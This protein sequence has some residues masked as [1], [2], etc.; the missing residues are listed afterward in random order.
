M[1][2]TVGDLSKEDLNGFSTAENTKTSI[3]RILEQIRRFQ[4]RIRKHIED[5]YVDFIPNHT[6]S[7]VYIEEGESLLRETEHLLKNVGSDARLALN[8]A[9]IELSQCLEELREVTL[10]LKLSHRILKIDDIFQCLEES[11]A[12]KEYLRALNLLGK[13][14]CLICSDTSSDV[15]VLFQKCECYDTIKVRYHIQSN[16]L[17]Q[18]LQARFES[19]VQFSEKTFPS[20]KSVNLQ[21][22]KD[23][24]QLQD[25]VL[26]LFEA[27]YNPMKL[28]DFLLENCLLPIITRPVSVEY[29][30]D[31]EDYFQINM[32]YS[33][34][35]ANKCLRPSYKQVF[36]H[37]K[38]LFECLSN[39]NINVSSDKTVFGV[40]G[41]HIKERFIKLLIEECLMHSIPETMDEFQEST[42]LE[43]L[44]QFEQMLKDISFLEAN[45]DKDL[46][47]FAEKFNFLF[48]ER[49]S[50][51]IIESAKSI[52]QKDLQDMM[53]VCEGN[54]SDEVKSNKFLFPQCM[55]SKSTLE[56]T[57]LMERIMRQT[58]NSPDINSCYNELNIF[59][60]VISTILNM[61]CC[62]VPKI[63]DKLLESIPQQSVLFYNNCMFL[64]HWVGKNSDM[65]IPT[66][67]VLVKTLQATGLRIFK[68]QEEKQQKIILEIMK[69]LDVS[70][71]H[72]IGSTPLKLIRQC[73]RQMELLKNVWL[74]VLPESI[75]NKTFS[76]ILNDFFQ[77]IIRRILCLEDISATVASELSELIGVILTKVPD[78]FKEKQEAF[79]VPSWMKIQQLQMIL[80][81]SL[82]EITDQWCDGAGILT[83][84]YK[85]EELRHLIRALF[86]NTDRRAKALSKII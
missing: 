72:S 44:K 67:S 58:T 25:T 73:L 69:N 29:C 28:C 53:V 13:L 47:N 50:V 80:N 51:K 54:T 7:D 46:S 60:P 27:R 65:G 76:F 59:L 45:T 64:A 30:I 68:A 21:V 17:Q 43:D 77:D 36:M 81:A 71:T 8:S 86:Q 41:N 49:F 15:D 32:S 55:I 83:A 24:S 39:I 5:N 1:V 56:L 85:A 63:H 78:L 19:L 35:E 82:Q 70:D 31:K 48:Q 23:I 52:M 3:V 79:Q 22:S 61:Y 11:N 74:N 4:D 9:N 66:H 37:V 84:N 33:I 14:K 40:I 26:A 57:K 75:Y 6:A 12:T 38:S 20:A 10:G 18:N 62:E 42:L 34:K 16:I 2:T